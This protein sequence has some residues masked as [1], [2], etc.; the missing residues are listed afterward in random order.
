MSHWKTK[1]RTLATFTTLGALGLFMTLEGG[2]QPLT[3]LPAATQGN[4]LQLAQLPPEQAM[5]L[6]HAQLHRVSLHNL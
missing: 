2:M 5:L 3:Q 6:Q 1:T 4:T